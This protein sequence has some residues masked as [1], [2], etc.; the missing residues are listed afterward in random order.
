MTHALRTGLLAGAWA[1]LSAAP[2]WAFNPCPGWHGDEANP[3]RHELFYSPYTHHW[4]HSIEHRDVYAVALS[5]RLPQERFCGVSLFRNSFGQPSAYVYAGKTWPGFIASQPRLYA[6]LSAGIL[7]GYTGRYQ[8]KVPLNVGG[9][10]PAV[11]PALG[12]RLG[13]SAAL[14]VQLLGTAAV[15]FGASWRY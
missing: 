8:D 2:A 9:F 11:I 1:V 15:M 14:E 3:P 10:S 12:Y 4:R 6:S 5:R 13:D 7:Y